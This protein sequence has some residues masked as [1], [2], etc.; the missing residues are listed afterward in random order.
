VI[1]R[2]KKAFQSDQ[3]MYEEGLQEQKIG[4][5]AIIAWW[6]FSLS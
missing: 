6:F 2:L 5:I 4:L 3:N 1:N